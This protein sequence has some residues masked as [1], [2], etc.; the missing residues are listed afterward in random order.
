MVFSLQQ[1]IVIVEAYLH[2]GSIKETQQAFLEKYPEIKAPAKRS[3]Q[4]LVKKWHKTGSV[5]NVKKQRPKLVWMPEVVSDIQQQISRSPQKS[6]RRL[7]QQLPASF[8]TLQVNKTIFY[9]TTGNLNNE[10][11][12]LFST[13]FSG[14]LLS[15][16]P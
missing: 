11:M 1:R 2:T 10:R 12:F 15:G 3:I 8:I 4:S 16:P 9:N 14:L 5:E 7:S 13:T 6:T